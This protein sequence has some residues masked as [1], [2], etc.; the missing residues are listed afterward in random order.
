MLSIKQLRNKLFH[1]I[2]NHDEIL[3]I[4]TLGLQ[5]SLIC[6]NSITYNNK[7][8]ICSY[9]VLYYTVATLKYDIIISSTKDHITIAIAGSLVLVN[10]INI[11][12]YGSLPYNIYKLNYLRKGDLFETFLDLKKKHDFV[13]LENH[14]F[15]SYLIFYWI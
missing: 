9:K 11:S 2:I 15:L 7:L 10:K 3:N 12:V 6:L 5:I 8:S 1:G 4:I 14:I 13:V